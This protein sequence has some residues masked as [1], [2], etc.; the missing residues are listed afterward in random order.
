[1]PPKADITRLM[2][3]Q[4]SLEG[5]VGIVKTEVANISKAVAAVEHRLDRME[6]ETQ[7]GFQRVYDKVDKLAQRQWPWTPILGIAG[8]LVTI[9]LAVCG[10]ILTV[11][12][13]LAAWGNVYFGTIVEKL[14]A[15][16]STRLDAL[17]RAVDSRRDEKDPR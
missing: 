13:A 6:G 14:D 17:E 2:E 12:L 4:G 3:A 8:M 7:G 10:G 15:K 5:Q 16:V 9:G 1:M 11:V